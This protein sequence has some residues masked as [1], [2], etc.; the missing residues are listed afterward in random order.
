MGEIQQQII[1]DAILERVT[2]ISEEESIKHEENEFP[3]KRQ[4]YLE[5]C[6][7]TATKRKFLSIVKKLIEEENVDPNAED[8]DGISPVMIAAFQGGVDTMKLLL[9][10]SVKVNINATDKNGMTPLHYACSRLSSHCS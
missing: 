10:L 5:A 1:W 8:S 3:T 9:S 6:L 7:R 4:R 2:K